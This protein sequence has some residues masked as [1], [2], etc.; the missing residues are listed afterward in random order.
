MSQSFLE[1]ISFLDTETGMHYCGDSEEFYR[2]LLLSYLHSGRYEEIWKA[3][4]DH[5]W[6]D[7][8]IAVHALKSTSLLV[9]ALKVSEGARL[10]EQAA[11]DQNT[12]YLLA[13]HQETMQ[14]YGQIL[15]QL[16]KVFEEHGRYEELPEV[17]ES[18]E[19]AHV[20]VVDDDAMNLRMAERMMQ[21]RFR[22]DCVKSGHLALEFLEKEIPNLILLDLHMP[23]MNGFEVMEQL[24]AEYRYRDIPVIF[25]TADN[26]REVEVKGFQMGALDFIAKPFIAD[27]M[28][29][30]VSRILELERLRKHLQRE[31]DRQTRLA[32]ERRHKVERMAKQVI[33]TL[34]STIDAKDTYTNGH[35]VRVAEYSRELAKRLGRT[36]QQQEDIYYMGL[37]HDIGKIGIPDY[38]INKP[39][40]LT[41][42]EY[43]IIKTHP[44]VGSEILKNISEIPGIELGARW[45]H[46]RYDGTG[47]P[48]GRQAE[49]ISIEARIIG[50]ADAYDAMTSKRSYRDILPQEEVRAELSKGIGTQFDPKIAKLMILMIDEDIE[51]NMRENIET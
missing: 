38:I 24:K 46:E 22:V 12:A 16:E 27:I 35:S 45:H 33:Q 41:E 11:K 40:K 44:V 25:L 20:L 30:R 14:M 5:R 26:E 39:G 51:Y 7:Y 37:L 48:D 2:E 13:Y 49:E 29:Q 21:D 50:V 8:R 18:Q 3:Y 43:E 9:G 1:Q 17:K 10:L 23:E 15:S 34:A 42:E 36:R 32:E 6:D 28:L 47:Y 4:E 19:K 31:V